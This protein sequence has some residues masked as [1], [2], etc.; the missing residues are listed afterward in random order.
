MV[1]YQV[2]GRVGA[3][4][5]QLHHHKKNLKFTPIDIKRVKEVSQY[6]KYVLV[7]LW[8]FYMILDAADKRNNFFQQLPLRKKYFK[9][10]Q[11]EIYGFTF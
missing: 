10:K 1:Y 4:D 8:L 6:I 9:K 2:L 3:K 7:N 5:A 11:F